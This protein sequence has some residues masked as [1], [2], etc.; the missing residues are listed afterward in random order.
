[1]LPLRT[2]DLVD[3]QHVTRGQRS[4]GT[5]K[6]R[7]CWC[8][9]PEKLEGSHSRCLET[10]WHCLPFPCTQPGR[11][12]DIFLRP[13]LTCPPGVAPCHGQLPGAVA[14]LAGYNGRLE[15][16]GACQ[17]MRKSHTGLAPWQSEK[18]CLSAPTWTL[19]SQSPCHPRSCHV[20]W[21]LGPKTPPYLHLPS[22]SARAL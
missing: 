15:G 1:M 19:A 10:G 8:P 2:T 6:H 20:G 12:R 9:A 13:T 5:E 4:S 18:T 22:G 17:R 7:V 21:L 16:H 11:E 3:P 14:S